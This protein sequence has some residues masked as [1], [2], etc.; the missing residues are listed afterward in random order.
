MLC[1]KLRNR[2]KIELFFCLMWNTHLPLEEEH[3]GKRTYFSTEFSSQYFSLKK[4][5]LKENKSIGEYSV[6]D[7]DDPFAGVEIKYEHMPYYLFFPRGLWSRFAWNWRE[8]PAFHSGK[9][10]A[11]RTFESIAFWTLI[12]FKQFF[13]SHSPSLPTPHNALAVVPSN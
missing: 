10:S 5:R 1:H 2:W 3:Q 4:L 12:Y 8:V 11:A 6:E 13:T 9:W 7:S